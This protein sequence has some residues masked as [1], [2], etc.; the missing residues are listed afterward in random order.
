MNTSQTTGPAGNG[1]PRKRHTHRFWYILTGAAAAL[2]IAGVAIVVAAVASI[3]SSTSSAAS[4]G[5]SAPDSGQQQ[6]SQ[7][8]KASTYNLPV[9]ST[10]TVTDGYGAKWAVT[11][12]SVHAY[13]PGQY[14]IADTPAG[15]H[16]ID[17]NVTYRALQ[18][19]ASPNPLDWETKTAAGQTHETQTTGD[20]TE[21]VSNDIKAGQV[22]RGDVIVPVASGQQRTSA[23][24]YVNGFDE[25]GSW[26]LHGA[27]QPSPAA[28]SAAAAPASPSALPPSTQDYS[29]YLDAIAAAGITAPA[30]WSVKTGTMIAQEWAYGTPVATTDQILLNGGIYPS[31]LQA[32]DQIIRT[33]LAS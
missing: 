32:M 11:V 1:Q 20:D 4:V 22:A 8:H 7:H 12:N 23:L 24:V 13:Q 2:F 9:G 19:T 31:H 10:L 30:D 21:L 15:T 29:G 14:S 25:A 6:P 5:R 3:P 26:S 27:S 18:G 17:A 16:L 33:Y 28:A